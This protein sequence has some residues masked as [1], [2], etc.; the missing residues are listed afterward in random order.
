MS[1][2]QSIADNVVSLK[3]RLP[4]YPVICPTCH[5]PHFKPWYSTTQRGPRAE[6][7]TPCFIGL[8]R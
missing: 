7:C 1:T 4:G 2:L 6:L 8:K 5:R 3:P